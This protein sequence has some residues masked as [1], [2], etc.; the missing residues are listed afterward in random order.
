LRFDLS[1]PVGR[2]RVL[3]IKVKAVIGV[4]RSSTIL[5]AIH[6]G[7][8]SFKVEAGAAQQEIPLQLSITW[9]STYLPGPSR[10]DVSKHQASPPEEDSPLI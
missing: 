3:H 1:T 6:S 4:D 2:K 9:L 7:D 5:F 10:K 8:V